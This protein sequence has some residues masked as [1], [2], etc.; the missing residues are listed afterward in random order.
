MLHCPRHFL[1]VPLSVL[2]LQTTPKH[3]CS[4]FR[5]WLLQQHSYFIWT[6]GAAVILFR[7]ELVL[8][9]GLI[10]LLELWEKRVSFWSLI[11]HA[12]PAGVIWL[13][14]TVVIDSVFWQ[15]WVW[16]EGEVL[17]FNTIL[18]KSH[19]WG[20][21][22]FLW[23][24]YS[25]LPR[26]LLLPLFFLPWSFYRARQRTIK[27]VLPVLGFLFLYSFLPHKELRFIIY[28][29]PLLNVIVALG[30]ANM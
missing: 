13:A 29:V 20:T 26:S 21:H 7:S 28:V 19:Q 23:Y 24:F 22:P 14:L 15:R 5:F 9:L 25:A 27:M 10:L 12:I 16:P 8:L 17:W 3:L 11:T 2:C 30:Y 6:A 4:H 1:S 18:N